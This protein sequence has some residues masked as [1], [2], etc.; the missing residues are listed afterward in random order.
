LSDGWSALF[1]DDSDEVAFD[2]LDV[3]GFLAITRVTKVVGSTGS[4]PAPDDLIGWLAANPKFSWSGKPV[5]VTVGGVAG[6][7]ID[8]S[9]KTGTDVFAYETG[10]MRVTTGEHVRYYVLPLDGPDLTIVVMSPGDGF[11]A[12]L[13]LA[14]ATIDSLEIVGR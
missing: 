9:V 13:D 4:I 1:P 12:L 10:N 7:M 14:Q 8:G 5:A 6:A 3:P 2:G 11:E